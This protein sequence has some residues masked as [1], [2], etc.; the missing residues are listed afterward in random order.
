MHARSLPPLRDGGHLETVVRVEEDEAPVSECRNSS[1]VKGH[2]L[3]QGAR[4]EF[5]EEG[6]GDDFLR[7]DSV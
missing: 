1:S 6:R 4:H 3:G 2:T 7:F 5:V